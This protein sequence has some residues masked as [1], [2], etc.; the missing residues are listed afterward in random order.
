MMI[1]LVCRA[2]SQL[3]I[4]SMFPARSAASPVVG[5]GLQ[6]DEVRARRHRAFELRQHPARGIAGNAGVDDCGIDASRIQQDLQLRRIATN[7]LAGQ[8]RCT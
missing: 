7:P 6:D 2:P 4:L 5:P 8:L 1:S 3:R